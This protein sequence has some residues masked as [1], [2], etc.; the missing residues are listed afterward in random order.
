MIGY[1][2]NSVN[3]GCSYQSLNFLKWY[4]GSDNFTAKKNGG[5]VNF[6]HL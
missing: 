5:R 1:T 6:M 4:D 3:I 2:L